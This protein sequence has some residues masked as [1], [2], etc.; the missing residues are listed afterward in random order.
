MA[1]HDPR[2]TGMLLREQA[3]ALRE[4]SMALRRLARAT[5]EASRNARERSAAILRGSMETLLEP[6]RRD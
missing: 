2:M 3:Q 4:E 6:A 1:D 5:A